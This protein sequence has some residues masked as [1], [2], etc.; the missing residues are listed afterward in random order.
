MPS[1]SMASPRRNKNIAMMMDLVGNLGGGCSNC[2]SVYLSSSLDTGD[3]NLEYF[4]GA[5]S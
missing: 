2:L 5:I 3:L 1:V 4:G